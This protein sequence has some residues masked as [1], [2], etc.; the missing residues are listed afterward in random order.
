MEVP[1]Q[2]TEKDSWQW[3]WVEDV[4]RKKWSGSWL[5]VSDPSHDLLFGGR[6]AVPFATLVPCHHVN[7]LTRSVQLPRQGHW[8]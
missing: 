7:I 3:S 1:K 5:Y 8:K 2:E 6:Q 4:A